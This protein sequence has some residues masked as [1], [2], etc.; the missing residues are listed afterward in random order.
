MDTEN[1]RKRLFF[2]SARVLY[3]LV[4]FS[5]CYRSQMDIFTSGIPCVTDVTHGI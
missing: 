5:R 3:Y 1:I 4:F 2:P